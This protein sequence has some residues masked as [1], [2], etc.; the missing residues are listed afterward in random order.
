M[1]KRATPAQT[2]KVKAM[3]SGP[4]QR[5]ILRSRLSPGD[6]V[7]LTAAVRDLH[8]SHPGRFVTDVR[9]PA[10]ALWENNPYIT[11]IDDE[12]PDARVIDCE[13][14]LIN[15]SNDVSLH[16]VH[17]Y[18]IFLQSALR[19][20]I[21]PFFF[22]G[23]IHLSA[24][25][26]SW[27]SQVEEIAGIGARFW[28]IC[29]GGKYDYTA[30]WWSPARYQKVVDA[31]AG[32]IQ[33][34]QVGASEHWHPDLR[35]VIDLRGETDLRQLVRLVYH[36]DGVVCG[37]TLLMH[38]AAAIETR[39][40]SPRNRAGVIVAGGREPPQWE[41]YPSHQY[42]HTSGALAC[43]EHGGCWKARVA[44]QGDG[45]ELDASEKMCVDVVGGLPRCM[46]LISADHVI[47]RIELFL[48]DE[49]RRTFLA[50]DSERDY[51]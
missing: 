43:C 29:A 30:K 39:P 1:K 48:N 7:M 14:P 41:S 51:E 35:G 22:G 32:R 9:T 45:S 11:Q 38:L 50:S 49:R 34:A 4:P 20:P 23:D 44:P 21:A 27:M 10:P 42:L 2:S 46:D 6:V 24:R 28:L 13:Y 31:F 47:D 25:E 8:L 37:V 17:G 19:V 15:L 26:K 36:S 33:F 18:R 16:F 40:G 12:D 3:W 5:L